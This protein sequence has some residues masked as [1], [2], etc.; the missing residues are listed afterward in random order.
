MAAEDAEEL[1]AA[2][3]IK[4]TE[5]LKLRDSFDSLGFAAYPMWQQMA[6]GGVEHTVRAL[7]KPLC[8]LRTLPL[9]SVQSACAA[10]LQNLSH[11]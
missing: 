2:L 10:L 1:L 6:I 9:Q 8:K 5:M 4:C 11:W 7:R 3:Y